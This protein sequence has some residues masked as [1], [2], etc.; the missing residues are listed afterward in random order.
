MVLTEAQIQIAR[1]RHPAVQGVIEKCQQNTDQDVQRLETALLV[2]EKKVRAVK[3]RNKALKRKLGHNDANREV[4]QRQCLM[5]SKRAKEDTEILSARSEELVRHNDQLRH[6]IHHLHKDRHDAA[7]RMKAETAANEVRCGKLAECI[8]TAVKFVNKGVLTEG[9]HNFLSGKSREMDR[10]LKNE[11]A[12]G[13]DTLQEI[14]ETEIA[15]DGEPY[16]PDQVCVSSS[17]AMSD[18]EW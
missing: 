4:H 8:Q 18:D 12:M 14:L 11:L 13:L 10:R 15:S 2:A 16:R 3:R 9:L 6:E 7:L 5:V 17:E 1:E